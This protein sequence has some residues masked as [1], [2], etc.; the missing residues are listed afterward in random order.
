MLSRFAICQRY[1]FVRPDDVQQG[2]NLRSM[3]DR[4]GNYMGGIPGRKSMTDESVGPATYDCQQDRTLTA[5]LKSAMRRGS[6]VNPAFGSTTPQRKAYIYGGDHA[7][8]PGPGTY[9][10]L[11]PRVRDLKRGRGVPQHARI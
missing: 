5:D 8:T 3:N 1:L 11:A 2:H 7:T 6:K 4:F 9:Q 10:R